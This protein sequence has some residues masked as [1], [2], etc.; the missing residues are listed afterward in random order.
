MSSRFHRTLPARPDLAQQ[1]KQAKELLRSYDAGDPEAHERIRAELPDKPEIAL[2]DAQFVLAREYGFT[3][4]ASLARHIEANAEST[5]SPIERMH[6][7]IERRDFVKVRRLFEE[8]PGLRQFINQP[9]FSFNSPPIVAFANDADMVDVLLDFGADPNGRSTWWAGGFHALYSA[10]GR[11]AERLLAAGAVPDACAAAHLDR[12]D[13]LMAMIE[14]DPAVVHE[15]GGDGQTPLHFATSQAMADLLLDTG[16]DIDARDV[17]HRSTPAE[18]MLGP[19]GDGRT[20][21]ARYLVDRGATADIF[22]AAALGLGRRVRDLLQ[23]DPAQL[24]WRIGDGAYGEHPPSSYHIYFWT[25][26]TGR[27]PMDVAAQYGQQDVLTVMREFASPRQRLLSACRRG[28]ETEVRAVLHEHP[29]ILESLQPSD[30]RLAA[31]AAWAGNARALTLMLELGFD[32]R[33]KGHEGGTALHCA[34]WEGSVEC[35][36]ALLAR[37][38]ARELVTIEDSQF[39]ATPLGWCMHGSLHANPNRDRARIARMLLE[40]GSNLDL[41]DREASPEVEAIL[42]AWE[43]S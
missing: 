3:D 17:D 1:K 13:L 5:R 11:A 29:R 6:A 34:A 42:R 32:P 18:W 7:A 16:A 2:A 31:D 40:A 37:A 26:G 23:A 36:A 28:E 27:S 38:D 35:V 8:N 19:H 39:H 12:I 24:E 33:V 41:G 21:L 25:I 43:R 30:H 4:W 14:K 9:I 10:T 22:L 20:E 15:R